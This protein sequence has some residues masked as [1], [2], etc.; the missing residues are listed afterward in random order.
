MVILTVQINVH[1]MS[2]YP[3][4]S[5]ERWAIIKII[6]LVHFTIEQ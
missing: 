4:Y 3:S 2:P 5:A 1:F 6:T